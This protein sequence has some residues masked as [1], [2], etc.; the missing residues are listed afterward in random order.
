MANIESELRQLLTRFGPGRVMLFVGSGMSRNV[1]NISATTMPTGG[2]LI[3]R[4]QKETNE[5]TDDLG[6]LAQLK[7]Q[8]I[9][10]H[11]LFKLLNDNFRTKAT[12]PHHSKITS[13]PWSVIYTTNYDDALEFSAAQ[14]NN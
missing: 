2:D 5:E 3:K 8:E 13:F 11:G 4:F 14:H 10:E 1:A 9:G 6:I 12:Y 7:I